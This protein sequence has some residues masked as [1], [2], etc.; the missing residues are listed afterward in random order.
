MAE[1]QS[2]GFDINNFI[3]TTIGGGLNAWASYNNQKAEA[4]KADQAQQNAQAALNSAN[5]ANSL[6]QNKT[7][8]VIIGGIVAVL[9]AFIMFRR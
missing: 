4:A 1:Q 9:I 8:L 7:K 3:N 6:A 5:L 2:S